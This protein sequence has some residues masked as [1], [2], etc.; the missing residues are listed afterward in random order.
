MKA[1]FKALWCDTPKVILC[2]LIIPIVTFL[3]FAVSDL[4]IAKKYCNPEL[5]FLFDMIFMGILAISILCLLAAFAFVVRL[6]FVKKYDLYSFLAA[7]ILIN[8]ALLL[9]SVNFVGNIRGHALLNVTQIYQPVIDSLEK[10]KQK[11]GDYPSSLDQL[12]PDYITNLPMP[13]SCALP[14]AEYEKGSSWGVDQY[15]TGGYRLMIFV[16]PRADLFYYLPNHNDSL[17]GKDNRC[18]RIN[19]WVLEYF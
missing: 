17:C 6:A 10:Y 19:D 18:E 3:N 5:G 14:A 2:S 15:P 8:N 9:G 16:S 13:Y 12:V 7:I 4:P 1:F 11:N